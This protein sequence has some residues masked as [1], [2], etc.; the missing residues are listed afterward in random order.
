[1]EINEI[2]RFDQLVGNGHEI[3]AQAMVTYSIDMQSLTA[4]I[5]SK[6]FSIDTELFSSSITWY[7]Q[8]NAFAHYLAI[9]YNTSFEIAAGVIAAVSPRMPWLR[10]KNV[11]EDILANFGRHSELSALEAAKEIG[12]AISVNV[13]MAIKIARGE[14]ISDTLTGT[15][16]RSFFNNIAYPSG[17]DSVTIDTWMMNAYCNVTGESKKV[18][19]KFMRSNETALGGTGAGY[20]VISEAV[21]IVANLLNMPANQIQAAYWIAESG[22]FDGGRTD[23]K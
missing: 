3:V 1:M 9:K 11:A 2:S 14:S 23:V 22:S 16:R 13:A 20:F 4:E 19:E 10:N 21:R 7:A 18:A 5:I 17:I 12:L 8:A 15:K 6:I